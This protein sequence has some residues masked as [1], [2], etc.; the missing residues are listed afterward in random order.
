MT[1]MALSLAKPADCQLDIVS[2][3]KVAQVLAA[4]PD[5]R[6]LLLVKGP[7]E[8]VEL[9]KNVPEIKAINYGGVAKKAN[10]IAYGKAVYL[11]E[12]ELAATRD[13]LARHIEL[14]VQQVPTAPVEV[15]DF[16]N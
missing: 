8:A 7:K 2:I 5:D 11:N 9:V 4:K 1:V 12:A 13:L 16:M 6:Y 14:Y 10:S 3:D 15:V